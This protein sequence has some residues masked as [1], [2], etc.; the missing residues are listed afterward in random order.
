MNP[1]QTTLVCLIKIE[2][3]PNNPEVTYLRLIAA[4]QDAKKKN[5]DAVSV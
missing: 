1:T 4:N 2:A 3:V 5:V